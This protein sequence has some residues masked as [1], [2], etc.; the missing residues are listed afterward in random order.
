MKIKLIIFFAF[1][2]TESHSQSKMPII[3]SNSPTVKI[4]ENNVMTTGWNLDPTLRPDIYTTGKINQSVSV[5]MITDIDSL[6]VYLKP[7][8]TFDFIVVKNGKDSCFNRF[9]SYKNLNFEYVK[10]VTKQKIPFILTPYNNIQIKTILNDRDSINL[11]F[12]TGASDFFLTKESIRKYFSH[13]TG[14][15][16]LQDISN[17]TFSIE[18]LKWERQQIYPNDLTAQGND[19]LFGWNLFDDKILEVNYDTNEITVH[20]KLPKIS[21]AYEKYDLKFMRD[22]FLIELAFEIDGKVYKDHFLFDTGFQKAIMLDQDLLT[23]KNIQPERLKTIKSTVLR[24]SRNEEIPMKTVSIDQ[25]I[26]GKYIVKNVPS[27]VNNYNKPTGYNTH[28]L[29]SDVI[30]RFNMIFDFQRNVVYL[31][32]NKLFAEKYYD[33]IHKSE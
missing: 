13:I 19:G 25:F 29:G 27:E 3:Y 32:P 15:I 22:Q 14:P 21:N 18:N 1:L 7:H 20:S 24:N 23:Q 26:F 8:E 11:H 12:D 2:F 9:Q 16:T 10:N 31:K 30:K 28:F 6:E 5:K 33:E 17:S 4:V